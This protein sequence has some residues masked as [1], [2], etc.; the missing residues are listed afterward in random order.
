MDVR[1]ESGADFFYMPTNTYAPKDLSALNGD[2]PL[3]IN[4]SL[5]K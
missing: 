1:P 4:T 2:S 5:S 3:L